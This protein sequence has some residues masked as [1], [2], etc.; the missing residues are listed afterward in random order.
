M[1][2][3]QPGILRSSES[4]RHQV[5]IPLRQDLDL[6]RLRRERLEKL[7][8]TMKKQDVAIMLLYNAANIRYAT[9]TEL[10]SVWTGSTFERYAVVGVEGEPVMCEFRTAEHTAEAVSD[11]VRTA[12]S[13][14]W[15][16][17]DAAPTARRWAAQI[18]G[19]M[20]EMG[21]SDE[22]LA[23]D[24][25][26]P[27][28]FAALS[29]A[30][31]RVVDAWPVC[32]DAR[33][34]KTPEE[35]RLLRF[36][37]AIGDRMMAAFQAAVQPGITENGLLAVLSA[38]LLQNGGEALFTRVVAA[39]RN[40]NPWLQEATD[41]VV[42]PGDLVGIDTDAYGFEGYVIDI[43]RTFLC[44][45]TASEG[46]KEAYRVA[47]DCVTGMVD[48]ARPGISFGDFAR[49]APELPDAY[50]KLR[51]CSMAHPAGLEDES[52]GIPYLYDPGAT[53]PDLELEENTVL[54]F[55]CYAGKE[56]APYG[57]KLEDQVLITRDGCER[58]C[59][60]PYEEK[61]L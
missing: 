57:V 2:I 41:Y 17:R 55:E 8:A 7:Q 43:S 40:T 10:M 26:D 6:E 16:G 54:C 35:V 47:Y 36:N 39:G 31:I 12:I 42:Q 4:S 59:A 13:W 34:V 18:K 58:L 22:V 27:T 19:I 32:A 20:Q 44:G 28:G 21:A 11:N 56:G 24:K 53:A 49:Q 51:Y 33:R 1:S 25:L 45:E 61:L 38:A 3:G 50:K 46:Q 37:G 23:I 9:G 5:D 60:F 29:D 52:P 14:Q 30:G 48:M 15:S